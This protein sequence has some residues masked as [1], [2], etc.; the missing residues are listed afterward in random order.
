MV[1][2]RIGG[3]AAEGE[4]RPYARHPDWQLFKHWHRK[5]DLC[6]LSLSL[7]LSIVGGRMRC[8]ATATLV[9]PSRCCLKCDGLRAFPPQIST[10]YGSFS[11]RHK[12]P[13]SFHMKRYSSATLVV[14]HGTGRPTLKSTGEEKKRKKEKGGEREGL[15]VVCHKS[16]W[17]AYSNFEW[18]PTRIWWRYFLI[19]CDRYIN[20]GF[21]SGRA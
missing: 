13:G 14:I 5:G 4:A 7:F 16:Q 11:G 12:A 3:E 17:P 21:L 9:L 19:L 18:G 1:Q 2:L 8:G 20:L 15:K 10:H 6:P